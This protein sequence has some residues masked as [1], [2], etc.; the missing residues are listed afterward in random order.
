MTNSLNLTKMHDNLLI[1]GELILTHIEDQRFILET[2]VQLAKA[3]QIYSHAL[4]NVQNQR[5]VDYDDVQQLIGCN[6]RIS[7]ILGF[8]LICAKFNVFPFGGREKG[9]PA[10][11]VEF[12]GDPD[13]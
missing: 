11:L 6:Q 10:G 13:A 8:S 5:Q 12:D 4:K 1:A 3:E 9:F 2:Q 7:A